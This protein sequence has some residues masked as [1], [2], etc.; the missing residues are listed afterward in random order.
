MSRCLTDWPYWQCQ[1]EQV[2]DGWFTLRGVVR[3]LRNPDPAWRRRD[4]Y[5]VRGR[6]PNFHY[7]ATVRPVAEDTSG[8]FECRIETFRPLGVRLMILLLAPM[9]PVLWM[10]LAFPLLAVGPAL[11]GLGVLLYARQSRGGDPQGRAALAW[12]RFKGTAFL[13]LLFPLSIAL[14]FEGRDWPARLFAQVFDAR[15]IA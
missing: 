12:R 11:I 15:E 6:F 10:A 7:R 9:V 2:G 4:Y 5:R 13:V 8:S 14:G 1:P 3:H